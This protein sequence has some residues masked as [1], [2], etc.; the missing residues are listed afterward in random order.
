MREDQCI[1]IYKYRSLSGPCGRQAIERALI[2]NELYWQSPASFNDPFD[3]SPVLYFGD[4]RA[5][6]AKF[7]KGAT[8]KIHDNRPRIIRRLDRS[9]LDREPASKTEDRL[10]AAWHEWLSD[11]AVAC[12]SEVHDDPLMW[13]HYAD[14]HRGVCLIFDEIATEQ[15]QWFA[16]PIVYQEARP[17][18]NLT[19]FNNPK[20]ME[21]GLLLK[22]NHWSYER[23]QRMIDWRGAP[24]Y[25]KF[26]A[27]SLKGIIL[28]VRIDEKDEAFVSELLTKRP[29]VRM[30]RAQID[31]TDFKLNMVPA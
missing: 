2:N 25:R 19:L 27:L 10:K 1:R 21:Q 4:S 24:G 13:A 20:I 15:T 30:F 8:A 9:V 23:E 29:E 11:T 7:H 17:R 28:G 26:P 18:V 16:F 12:F 3:C 14:S 31:V 5:Q 22:S 6:R